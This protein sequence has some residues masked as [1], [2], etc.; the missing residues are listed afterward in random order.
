M[1]AEPD[2]LDQGGQLPFFASASK[3]RGLGF[4]QE[5]LTF[6]EESVELEDDEF[7]RRSVAI[8]KKY[9]FKIA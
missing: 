6:M 5:G 3:E 7:D 8:A 1:R 9:E 4:I 2:P